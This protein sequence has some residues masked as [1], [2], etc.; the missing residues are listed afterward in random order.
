M[1]VV[2]RICDRIIIVAEGQII[3]DGTFE[4]LQEAGHA[5]SLERIFTQ[6]TSA[7]GHADVAERFVQAFE[8]R[9][10]HD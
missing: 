1:D 3:A 5:A 8:R 4:Q 6:L 9:A 10:D 7:G 2:E